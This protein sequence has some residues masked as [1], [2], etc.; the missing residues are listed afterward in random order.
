[1]RPA[2]KPSLRYAPRP[3]PL[4][5]T[6]LVFSCIL[7]FFYQLVPSFTH[8][9]DQIV[10]SVTDYLDL[11]TTGRNLC[12]KEVG[13][14]YCCRLLLDAEPCVSECR[15]QHVDR[16]TQSLTLEYDR[17]AS[18]C[19]TEYEAACPHTSTSG[20]ASKLHS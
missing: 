16:V 9:T 15:T 18:Q 7:V 13:T 12:T 5:A 1:M 2:T 4:L 3:H 8:A 20:K 6:V 11:H 17:C 10:T 19:L 14:A